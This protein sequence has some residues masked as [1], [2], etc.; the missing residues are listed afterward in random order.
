MSLCTDN[1]ETSRCNNFLSFFCT[2]SLILLQYFIELLLIKIWSLL[3]LFTHLF[4]NFHS[5][6]APFFIFA[7]S[8]CQSVFIGLMLLL[9]LPFSFFIR[10]NGLV[11]CLPSFAV[12]V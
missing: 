11:V 4:N 2:D 6:A 12:N 1:M 7:F 10:G 5:L 8:R 3:Q 9:I